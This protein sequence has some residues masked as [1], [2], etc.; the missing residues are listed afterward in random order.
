VAERLAC[1]NAGPDAWFA[2]QGRDGAFFNG[3]LKRDR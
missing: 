2:S 3:D 1:H